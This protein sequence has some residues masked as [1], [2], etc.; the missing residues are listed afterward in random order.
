[1]DICMCDEGDAGRPKDPA[2]R[3]APRRDPCPWKTNDPAVHS[4]AAPDVPGRRNP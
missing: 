2:G 1:M 4:R 3:D